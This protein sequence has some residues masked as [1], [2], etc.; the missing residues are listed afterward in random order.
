MEEQ[1]LSPMCPLQLPSILFF[2]KF[3]VTFLLML[4]TGLPFLALPSISHLTFLM[5]VREYNTDEE[6]GDV[7]PKS[8][9]PLVSGVLAP[10]FTA[11]TT[12]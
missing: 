2:G 4:Y 12:L 5:P 8:Q 3:Q 6:K 11:G 1:G 10:K 9:S 7:T